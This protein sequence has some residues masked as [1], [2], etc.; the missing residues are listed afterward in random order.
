MSL[1][2]LIGW[3]LPIHDWIPGSSLIQFDS[4]GL[5]FSLNFKFLR[6]AGSWV[7]HGW[8]LS[9]N[10]LWGLKFIQPLSWREEEEI[11]SFEC[12][13]FNWPTISCLVIIKWIKMQVL[14]D[15]SSLTSFIR[16]HGRILPLE[17]ECLVL[18]FAVRLDWSFSLF[19]ITLSKISGK[20]RKDTSKNLKISKQQTSSQWDTCHCLFVL[21]ESNTGS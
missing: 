5:S 7:V 4:G 1:L 3:R 16:N 8:W 9:S 21:W 13:S 14:N 10:E 19:K 20:C 15:C 17:N 12:I 2:S 6:A 18:F 11:K